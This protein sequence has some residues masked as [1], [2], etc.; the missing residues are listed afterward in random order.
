MQRIYFIISAVF[1]LA[2]HAISAK[3]VFN[4]VK[5]TLSGKVINKKTGETLPGVNIYINDLKTGTTSA[6]DGTYKLENLPQSKV[7][8]QVSLVGYKLLSETIDLATTT[9]KDFALE[10]TVTELHEI[11]VTG[12]SQGAE[13]NRTATPITT[14]S[15]AQLQQISSNN[16]IDALA[17]QPGISQITTG[18]G[19]SKPVIRGLGYNRVVTVNDGI[20]QEGQQW[21]DEHGIE[22]DEFSVSK[23]EILK[24]PASLMYGSDAMAGVIHFLSAP[25]LPDGKIQGNLLTNY[26]TNNGLVGVS[27][28]IAGNL[29]GVIWDVRYSNK[30]AHAYQNKYDGYVLNSGFKENSLSGI[31]GVNKSW[32]YSHLHFS[33][34]NFTPEIV[35]GERDSATGKFTKPINLGNN[36]EGVAIATNDDFKSY[37]SLTPFQKIHHYKAVLNNSFILGNGSLKTTLGFQQNQRQEYGNVLTPNQYGLFFLLN[38]LNYDARYIFPEKNHLNISVGIN[39]MQQSSQNKGIEFLVPEYKLF[40]AGVFTFAKK[41]IDKLDISGG[42]RYDSRTQQG[43]DLYLDADG[44]PTSVKEPG[45]THRFTA[46]NSTFSGVSGSVGATY[47]FT[48]D[49]YTKLNISRGF[50]APNISEIGANGVHDGTVRYEIGNPNL[51]AES[52]FQ[53]DYALGLNT[54]HVTAELNLFSN[55]IHNFIFP[56]KL[57][58][59]LGGDSLTEGYQTFQYFTADARLW[60]GE[61]SMDIHPHPIDWLHIEN[62]FSFVRSQ[63]MNQPD[64][65]KYLPFTPPAKFTTEVRAN[66]KNLTKTMHNAYFKVGLEHYFTQNKF[67][68]AY[69][70]ETETP[71]YTLINVGLGTDF[72]AKNR[73]FCSLYISANN[74]MDV[75][76]QSH[77]SRLKYLGENN[78]TGRTGVYNMGRNIS[79]KLL[80]PIDFKK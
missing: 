4:T 44:K 80:V 49:I 69:G 55:N 26:Q 38:T 66:A 14:I 7:I 33:V 43:K 40:D 24:G 35:E 21:G 62:T 2:T 39:G 37:S 1:L 46:F 15:K 22:I 68:S 16:I 57:N 58:S 67:Y 79:L 59:V 34:Y 18:S 60:G 61:I 71:S 50:R 23:V 19:I 54:Q 53:F 31:V 65:T 30:M 42:L 12:L 74:L 9:T 41:T 63:Q 73:T 48:E 47:Q 29:K 76:Y 56:R 78:V 10:E 72:V 25:T 17:T 3:N 8:V 51:K 20:R 27:G 64:S 70:T 5:T 32:G 75:A 36:T 13:K 28:N 45:D 6:I 52:S 77:L 11:V